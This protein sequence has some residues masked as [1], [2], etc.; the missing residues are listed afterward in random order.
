MI[1]ALI[2]VTVYVAMSIVFGFLVLLLVRPTQRA[3]LLPFSPLLGLAGAV[4][5]LHWQTWVGP[6]GAAP[7][8]LPVA[9]LALGAVGF[10]VGART[11]PRVTPP[12]LLPLV[13]GVVPVV[14]ALIPS[15]LFNTSR[16]VLTSGS[17][18]A[19]YYISVSRWLIEHPGTVLPD[20]GTGPSSGVDSPTYGSALT[21]IELPFR[22]GQGLIQAWLSSATGIDLL[23]G[24]TPW[25]AVSLL[26]VALAA[27]MLLR[28][29]GV[30]NRWSLVGGLAV[31]VSL[32]LLAQ[33]GAQN[34][35]CLLGIAFALATVAAVNRRLHADDAD[36]G[37]PIWV[38]ALLLAATVGVYTELVLFIGPMLVAQVLLR[39]G[40]LVRSIGL[41]AALVAL[42]FVISPPAWI[43]GGQAVLAVGSGSTNPPLDPIAAIVTLFGPF[44]NLVIDPRLADVRWLGVVFLVGLAAVGILGIALAVRSRRSRAAAIGALAA[45]VLVLPYVASQGY[46]YAFSRGVDMFTPMLICLAVA[47]FATVPTLTP[48][49]VVRWLARAVVVG[50]IAVNVA[51]YGVSLTS[52]SSDRWVSPEFDE[53]REWMT[54][55]SIGDGDNLGM[56][57]PV[58]FDQVWMV[59]QLRGLPDVS[60]PYLR[61]D[62]GYVGTDLPEFFEDGRSALP[63]FL[64]VGQG[65]AADAPVLE[66]NE[67]F[68][69]LDL[70][71]S[72]YAVAMPASPNAS[73]PVDLT[74]IAGEPRLVAADPATVEIAVGD[75]VRQVTVRLADVDGDPLSTQVA[76]T[77]RDAGWSARWEGA[78]VLV[79]ERTPGSS[80]RAEVAIAASDFFVASITVDD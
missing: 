22:Y 12:D 2:A 35:D 49:P 56:V 47:G 7:W 69:L 33:F 79:L 58:F 77:V 37:I 54:E 48:Q 62:L 63:P 10:F 34:A 11:L 72:S 21:A 39:S 9:L 1:A 55:R 32:S 18:D 15:F 74:T 71:A 8:V 24:Y 46:E 75:D 14:L 6:I 31:S 4:V 3:A 51:A 44:R 30:A 64:L 50:W 41:G 59:D 19:A 29:F 80:V 25:K 43:R 70:G 61:G 52:D 78:G 20:M 16:P 53:A 5:I 68:T 45:A 23:D 17:H 76:V 65:I 40:G 36:P 28:S 67:K 13:V 57:V 66:R 60:Y 27:V 42:S 73:W 38:P 26:L